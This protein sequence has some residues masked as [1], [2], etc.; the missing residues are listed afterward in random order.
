MLS[1]KNES[2]RIKS[3]HANTGGSDA[4]VKSWYRNCI[5]VPSKFNYEA[6]SVEFLTNR[7]LN[8][9]DIF[10]SVKDNR[11]AFYKK[12]NNKFEILTWDDAYP[13]SNRG[14]IPLVFNFV[15]EPIKGYSVVEYD[16]LPND[17]LK[18]YHMGSPV[19]KIQDLDELSFDDIM[20]FK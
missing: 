7:L 18:K 11:A 3:F 10:I 14:K 6:N 19:S 9:H 2:K 12:E 17:S 5:F 4:G 16:A 20:K 13:K 15:Y 8:I 1:E